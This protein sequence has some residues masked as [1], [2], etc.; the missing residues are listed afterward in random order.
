MNK[1]HVISVLDF[2]FLPTPSLNSYCPDLCFPPLSQPSS[3][4]SHPALG[5]TPDPPRGADAELPATG[6]APR[7]PAPSQPGIRC[8]SGLCAGPDRIRA[9]LSPAAPTSQ[10]GC[11]GTFTPQSQRST[12]TSRR[13][14]VGE[15][16]EP[17]A[18][19][20]THPRASICPTPPGSACPDTTG[21]LT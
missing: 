6:P 18:A 1:R 11:S 20:T 21:P 16:A 4:P 15:G 7:P 3:Q 8:A 5:L 17:M 13:A 12:S 2:P 9:E 19:P 10:V 14:R